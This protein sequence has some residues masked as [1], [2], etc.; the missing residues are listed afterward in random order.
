VFA[1]FYAI[2]GLFGLIIY[3]NLLIANQIGRQGA[4][5]IRKMGGNNGIESPIVVGCAGKDGKDPG[6]RHAA[7]QC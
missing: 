7:G 5:A 3:Q 1:G 4:G 2:T 6:D